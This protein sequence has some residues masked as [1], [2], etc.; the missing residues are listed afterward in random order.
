MSGKSTE[1]L[2]NRTGLSKNPRTQSA[3]IHVQYTDWHNKILI[4]SRHS[5]AYC[6]YCI[7]ILQYCWEN[8]SLK[9]DIT[10]SIL[11]PAFLNSARKIVLHG[12]W[13]TECRERALFLALTFACCPAS[14]T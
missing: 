6:I 4:I 3:K 9:G 2:M 10:A 7:E 1:G 14:L 5:L 13:W 12:K 11:I 8:K